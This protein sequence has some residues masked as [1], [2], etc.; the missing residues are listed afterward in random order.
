MTNK[1][2]NIFRMMAL[3]LSARGGLLVC[4]VIRR[5][6]I[7]QST[8]RLPWAWGESARRSQSCASF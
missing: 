4:E 5:S 8:A 3:G 2:T 7:S 1:I 6:M